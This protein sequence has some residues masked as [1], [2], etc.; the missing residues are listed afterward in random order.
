MISDIIS[1]CSLLLNVVLG[2]FTIKFGIF[3]KKPVLTVQSYYDGKKGLV[4]V[5]VANKGKTIAKNITLKII[6]I[7]DNEEEWQNGFNNLNKSFKIEN[8]DIP[9]LNQIE[10][11]LIRAV[12]ETMNSSHSFKLEIS[13]EGE[14]IKKQNLKIKVNRKS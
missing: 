5:I 6:K 7:Y 2:Y 4:S 8:V 3:D 14:K 9:P 11:E 12:P 13:L 1:I 10:D